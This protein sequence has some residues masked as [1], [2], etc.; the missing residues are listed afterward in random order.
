MT[1]VVKLNQKQKSKMIPEIK[2]SLNVLLNKG[3]YLRVKWTQR[4][5]GDQLTVNSRKERRMERRKELDRCNGSYGE[6]NTND[7]NNTGKTQRTRGH[8]VQDTSES[9]CCWWNKNLDLGGMSLEGAPAENATSAM[10]WNSSGI[11]NAIHFNAA[12]FGTNSNLGSVWTL[13]E[14]AALEP[15]WSQIKASGKLPHT[16]LFPN[17]RCFIKFWIYCVWCWIFLDFAMSNLNQK[18]IC[19]QKWI[20]LNFLEIG[21]KCICGRAKIVHSML[22][23]ETWHPAFWG[24]GVTV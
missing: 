4:K 8:P 22:C 24:V 5:H 20:D 14:W 15:I 1:H 2:M 16:A 11:T 17:S 7:N 23:T 18:E 13:L 3:A 21:K 19:F 9:F 12:H 6:D 10:N